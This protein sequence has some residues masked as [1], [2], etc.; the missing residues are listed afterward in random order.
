MY[1]K[2]IILHELYNVTI[3]RTSTC[4]NVCTRAHTHTNTHTDVPCSTKFW[5]GE[6]LM[7]TNS[8]NIWQKIFWRMVTVIHHTPVNAVLFLNNMTGW[9]LMVWLKNL[10]ITLS[11]FCAI[12]YTQT[13]TTHT[14]THKH[15]YTWTYTH[16]V[17]LSAWQH[18]VKKLCRIVSWFLFFTNCES[19]P[20]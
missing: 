5:R 3:C 11:N 4:T 15:M 18:T 8:S 7:D 1:I 16:W 20:H 19:F 14:H 12:H 10:K 9:I 6:I 13:N 2:S 17:R